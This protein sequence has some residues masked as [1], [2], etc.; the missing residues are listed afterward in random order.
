MYLKVKHLC[1]FRTLKGPIARGVLIKRTGDVLWSFFRLYLDV[2]NGL[3]RTSID[4]FCCLLK[5]K[6][7]IKNLIEKILHL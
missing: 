2:L 4:Y 6:I 5:V 7:V 3:T 1:L